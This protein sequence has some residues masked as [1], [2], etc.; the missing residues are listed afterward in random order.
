MAQF[1]EREK[2]G[3]RVARSMIRDMAHGWPVK[4]LAAQPVDICGELSKLIGD[5]Y[6]FE[7]GNT[8]CVTTNDSGDEHFPEDD[9]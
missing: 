1:T 9:R 3:I 8:T 4:E 2:E 7:S 5:I 6:D